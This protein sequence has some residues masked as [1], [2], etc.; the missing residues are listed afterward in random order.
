MVIRLGDGQGA[1][2]GWG[3][4]R[5]DM[6]GAEAGVED[7]VATLLRPGAAEADTRVLLQQQGAHA[8]R[9][10]GTAAHSARRQRGSG[11]YDYN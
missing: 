8:D 4:P 10:R 11:K 3:G 7:A 5:A 1:R 2:G 9:G 6:A